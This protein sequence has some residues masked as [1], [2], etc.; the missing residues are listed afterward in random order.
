MAQ[1][2][3]QNGQIDPKAAIAE[4]LNAVSPRPLHSQ[5]PSLEGRRPADQPAPPSQPHPPASRPM[6]LGGNVTESRRMEGVIEGGRFCPPSRIITAGGDGGGVA[7]SPRRGPSS[8]GAGARRDPAGE[9]AALGSRGGSGSG[10]HGT[11]KLG[12]AGC[13]EFARDRENKVR[14]GSP[15]PLPKGMTGELMRQVAALDITRMSCQQ[16]RRGCCA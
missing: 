11:F 12:R 15:V 10:E 6:H 4:G 5:R 2:R 7:Q 1:V 13:G 3:S 9:T 14:Q 16:V 8:D